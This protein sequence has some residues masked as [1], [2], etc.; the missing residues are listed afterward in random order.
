MENPLFINIHKFCE[1]CNQPLREEEL[2]T[3]F[4]KRLEKHKVSCPY[5]KEF[6]MPK[7]YVYAEN[8][9]T[10]LTHGK[11]GESFPILPPIILYKEFFNVLSKSGPDI[12]MSE[13]LV[14]EHPDI[15]W[16]I[17]MYFK[18]LKLPYFMIDLD[19]TVKHQKA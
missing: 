7:F 9:S 16:N 14:S 19:Y 15:F 12:V 4:E 11:Q 10:Y 2:L 18:L 17:I 5:C 8:E 3:R 6:F 13:T 1:H